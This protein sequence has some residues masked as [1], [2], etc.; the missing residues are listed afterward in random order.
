MDVFSWGEINN[1]ARL[2]Y[3]LPCVCACLLNTYTDAKS[4]TSAMHGAFIGRED[5]AEG[6]RCS[7]VVITLI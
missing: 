5:P 6:A 7:S 1:H 3:E 4:D 2:V